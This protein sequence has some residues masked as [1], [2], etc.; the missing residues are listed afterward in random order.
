MT[1]IWSG[2]TEYFHSQDESQILENLLVLVHQTNYITSANKMQ[3]HLLLMVLTWP[4]AVFNS[5]S[6]VLCGR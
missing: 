5:L 6:L 3:I 1:T 2:N 4:K